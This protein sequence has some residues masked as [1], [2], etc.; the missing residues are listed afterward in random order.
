MFALY[1]GN[2]NYSSWSLRP[3]L[4]I[5]NFGIPFTEHMVSVAWRE[6][7]AALKPLAGNA[8]VP[9]L[10]DDGFQDWE[11]IA[12]AEFLAKRRP[13]MSPAD[14]QAR[15]R[16]HHFG[17]N[18]CRLR[19][20]AHGD[21][22]ESQDEAQGKTGGASRAAQHRPHCRNLVRGGAHAIR[23][24]RRALVVRRFFGGRRD[25]CAG[26]LAAAHLQHL[27]AANCWS[28]TRYVAGTPG[29]ARS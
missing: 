28:L 13:Q 5:K 8:R 22:D 11:S 21:A 26:S 7:I 17:G 3:W 10:H 29:G 20:L 25:I 15:A 14:P 4:L 19:C 9:C 1:I 24:R 16:A 6:Y 23:K 27:L 2:K 18:A 12:I